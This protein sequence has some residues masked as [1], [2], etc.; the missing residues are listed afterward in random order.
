MRVNK[1]LL[2][3]LIVPIVIVLV[4]EVGAHHLL[5]HHTEWYEQHQPKS[6]DF[7][8]VGS[9]RVEAGFDEHAFQRR[10]YERTGTFQK[11][12]NVG[13]GNSTMAAHYLG[14]RNFIRDRGG[15]KGLTVF[16]ELDKGIPS[17]LFAG[18][19]R[20]SWVVSVPVGC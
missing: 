18:T 6:I 2:Q 14:I 9:S 20:D 7:V 15:A 8:F 5:A 19:W 10:L 1:R 11:A 16:F 13:A 3:W 17:Q 12:W 4:A